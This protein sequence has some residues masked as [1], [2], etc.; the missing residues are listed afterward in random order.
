MIEY[1]FR[2]PS[3]AVFTLY[4]YSKVLDYPF[5]VPTAGSLTARLFSG[6]AS[7][8]CERAL[9]NV[10]MKKTIFSKKNKRV[11]INSGSFKRALALRGVPRE[12]WQT[13]LIYSTIIHLF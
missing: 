4:S 8:S 7:C 6:S 5:R 13:R 3:A 2:V 1:R 9:P 12:P 11:V 10:F